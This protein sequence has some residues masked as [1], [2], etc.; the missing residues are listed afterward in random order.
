MKKLN[1]ADY[2]GFGATEEERRTIQKLFDRQAAA[3]EN[4]HLDGVRMIS[5]FVAPN[6]M[7]QWKLSK[8]AKKLREDCVKDSYIVLD[9]L[10]ERGKLDHI[11][12]P[13][14]SMQQAIL[15][16][17][18]TNKYRFEG[19]MTDDMKALT[20]DQL[21]QVSKLRNEER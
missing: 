14:T 17:S 13:P 18:N 21:D 19:L 11:P 16:E 20:L 5:E 8:Q 2:A 15:R 9:K 4:P 6:R 3:R 10:K 7:T 12:V 1:M